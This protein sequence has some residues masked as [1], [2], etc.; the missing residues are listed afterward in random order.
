MYIYMYVY[1]HVHIYIYI[2]IYVDIYNHGTMDSMCTY[3]IYVTIDHSGD[4]IVILIVIH[5]CS[6]VINY[7]RY[8]NH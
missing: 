5:G 2:Y 6:T 4:G 8:H 3:I 1:I 7:R